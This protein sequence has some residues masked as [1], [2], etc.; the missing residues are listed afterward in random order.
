MGMYPKSEGSTGGRQ[1][2]EMSAA[3]NQRR[4]LSNWDP[5]LNLNWV[6]HSLNLMPISWIRLPA[7]V[8]TLHWYSLHHRGAGHHWQLLSKFAHFAACLNDE[9]CWLYFQV[10]CVQLLPLFWR[11]TPRFKGLW[12]QP[13]HRADLQLWSVYS[14]WQQTLSIVLFWGSYPQSRP[15]GRKRFLSIRY[16]PTNILHCFQ[17]PWEKK[18]KRN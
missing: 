3:L 7:P 13:R 5:D 8:R 16:C 14:R 9:L 10:V 1:G 15:Q 12:Q 17:V 11:R 4:S 18:S 6:L 2:F